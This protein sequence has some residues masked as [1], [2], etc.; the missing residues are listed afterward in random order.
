VIA[1]VARAASRLRLRRYVAVSTTPSRLRRRR[2][3]QD[4]AMRSASEM[5]RR[6]SSALQQSVFSAPLQ[7]VTLLLRR[8]SVSLLRCNS[9][10][11]LRRS[12][13]SLLR[14]RA[15]RF[16]VAAA[17]R[18]CTAAARCSGV[19]L[20]CRRSAPRIHS[21]GLSIFRECVGHG[22]HKQA[23][24]ARRL[25]GPSS[26]CR[27]SLGRRRPSPSSPIHSVPSHS[28]SCPPTGHCTLKGLN[29]MCIIAYVGMTG[30]AATVRKSLGA[31]WRRFF[32]VVPGAFDTSEAR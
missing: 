14:R 24:T 16:Y 28:L 5:Q 20:V 11:L 10:S 17:R 23:Y 27:D 22:C 13:V 9:V 6:A 1:G 15:C 8:N 12:S 4:Y 25:S 3:S 19:S 7:R 29:G 31:G 18:L 32:A 2:H 26:A 30:K 21:L